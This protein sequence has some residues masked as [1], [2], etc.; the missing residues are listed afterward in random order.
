MN[1]SAFIDHS[2]KGL[3]NLIYQQLKKF[4]DEHKQFEFPDPVPMSFFPKDSMTWIVVMDNGSFIEYKLMTTGHSYDLWDCD[5]VPL[6]DLQW[7]LEQVERQTKL[8]N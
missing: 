3:E 2:V 6:T 7:I 8:K 5:Q 4:L 1:L